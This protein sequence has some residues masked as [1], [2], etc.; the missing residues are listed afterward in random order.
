MLGF[1]VKD[2]RIWA[3]LTMTDPF[4]NFPLTETRG[5][6]L[7]KREK[8]SKKL[9]RS[10]T[11]NAGEQNKRRAAMTKDKQFDVAFEFQPHINRAV[12]VRKTALA[13]RQAWHDTY[14]AIAEFIQDKHS[15]LTSGKTSV[16]DQKLRTKKDVEAHKAKLLKDVTDS[17]KGT[18]SNLVKAT[19]FIIIIYDK[20]SA[21]FRPIYHRHY[22]N[23]KQGVH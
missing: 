18:N 4:K 21:Q 20:R 22:A 1:A 9:L 10:F 19:H 7:V 5:Y 14:E 23:L 16:K 12:T 13:G 6:A 11:R 8:E 2:Q 17:Y 15:A 3:P